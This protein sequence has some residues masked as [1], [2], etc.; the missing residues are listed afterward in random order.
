MIQEDKEKEKNEEESR[1]EDGNDDIGIFNKIPEDQVNFNDFK[2]FYVHFSDY[3]SGGEFCEIIKL[4]EFYNFLFHIKKDFNTKIIIN[5][6][7]NLKSVEKYLIKFIQVSYF[8]IFL[9][10][11]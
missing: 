6:G 3:I 7:E 2:Y 8:H 1:F 11:S 5:F 4:K 9:N 10:K